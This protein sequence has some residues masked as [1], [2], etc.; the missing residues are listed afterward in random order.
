MVGSLEQRESSCVLIARVQTESPN[1]GG[2]FFLELF[3]CILPQVN[4][5][6]SPV[7][8]SNV[9]T[10]TMPRSSP[11]CKDVLS[12]IYLLHPHVSYTYQLSVRSPKCIRCRV[13]YMKVEK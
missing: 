11:Y 3:R 9:V 4:I 5:A 13:N 10:I 7:K 6:P 2:D 12:F 1:D 8:F